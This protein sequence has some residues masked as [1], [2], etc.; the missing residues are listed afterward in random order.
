LLKSFLMK[1]LLLASS[2][3]LLIFSQNLFATHLMG[4]EITW[5]CLP[6][7]QFQ[8]TMKIYR[9]CNGSTPIDVSNGIEVFNYPTVGSPTLNIPVALISQTDISAGCITCDNP[10]GTSGAVEEYIF[11][12]NPIT[13]TGIPPSEGWIFSYDGCCRNAAV[14]N[15]LNAGNE[16]FVLRSKM[17]A[18]N[19]RNTE[20]CFD[21]SPAF[22]EKPAL[23]S[24]TGN[25]FT[26]THNAYDN[27]LDS[28][29]Y[30]WALALDDFFGPWSNSNPPSLNYASGYTANS[31]LPGTTQNPSNQP[32]VINSA[33]G[34]VSFLSYTSG[35][36]VTVIKV[37]AW[38]CGTKVA[39]VYREIQVTIIACSANPSPVITPPFQDLNGN[40]TLYADTVTAGE[41]VNF[42]LSGSDN[43]VII[44]NATGN[45]FGTNFINASAGCPYPPCATLSYPLPDN[46]FNSVSTTFNWQTDCNH[47][48][49][50]DEC[51]S[52][53]NTY[54]FAFRMEDDICPVPGQSMA[55]ISITVIGDSVVP[56][57]SLRC[58]SVLLNGDVQLNWVAPVN[59]GNTFNSYRVYYSESLND[60]FTLIDSIFNINTTTYLHTG[61]N[62]NQGARYYFIR[63]RSGC[64]GFI[65]NAAPDTLATIFPVINNSGNGVADLSW[66][67]LSIPLPVS[68]LSGYY[69]IYRML[70]GDN[71]TLIDSTQALYYNDTV[72]ICNDSI[73]YRVEIA[74]NS[75][76]VSIS[77]LTGDTILSGN[78][79][80]DFIANSSGF[81][82]FEFI[83]NSQN[84]LF[85]HW[86]FGDGDTS[87]LS[88]PTHTFT[89]T[90]SYTVTLTAWNPCDTD[91]FILPL[92]ITGINESNDQNTINIYPNPA[93]KTIAIQ[94]P[95]SFSTRNSNCTIINTMG[96]VVFNSN[97]ES[98]YAVFDVSEFS[99]GVYYLFLEN[100]QKQMCSKKFVISR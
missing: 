2:F 36:F 22:A 64:D 93:T 34:A 74:D 38:K 95:Y 28:L 33:T 46:G 44:L 78:V 54:T 63:T 52:L 59:T 84:A 87:G 62:A 82:Q 45:Q 35:N 86:D 20:P 12:T 73:Y 65:N 41:L 19:G 61:A 31:P 69:R 90:G 66:N 21:A 39:E 15:I 92:T 81:L 16:G 75:G 79:V 60:P 42:T 98:R 6:N 96:Q 49:H 48:G 11:R 88:N 51:S 18:F 40:Y 100:E 29:S 8:F 85:Y 56:S 72:A 80:S 5:V 24:C 14:T 9:D 43:G 55:L 27:E 57:P 25:P 67:E 47:V 37:E 99:S 83:N 13:L 30:S 89:D 32:A 7:G 76:C 4:G 23:V 97:Y 1:K 17:F 3:A 94:T 71:W 70:P 53:Y 91:T 50:F 58:S 68:T 77:S 10:G 26:Y